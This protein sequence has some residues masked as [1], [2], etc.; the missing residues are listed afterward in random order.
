MPGGGVLKRRWLVRLARKFGAHRDR[1]A[2]SLFS[3]APVAFRSAFTIE[4]VNPPSL[5]MTQIVWQLCALSLLAVSAAA[6]DMNLNP[7]RPTIANS[8]A[9]QSRGVLQ[10]EA[11]YDAYPRNPPG[12]Q[13][14][15][16][17]LFTYTPL[18]RL[19]FDFDWSGFNHQQDDGVITDGVGAIQ[20]GGKVEAKRNSTIGSR[21]ELHFSMRPNSRPLQQ[22]R[23]RAMVSKQFCC[24]ITT[25]GRTVI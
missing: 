17:T 21:R 10:G 15:L 22:V 23:F 12:N 13:Q 18:A 14:T 8:A 1:P 25:M 4:Q 11:G 2:N 5:R 16:D 7:T 19:R 24:P 9:I 3:E 20:I 6:Q